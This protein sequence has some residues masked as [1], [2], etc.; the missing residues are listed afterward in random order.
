MS[1]CF[2]RVNSTFSEVSDVI[3]SQIKKDVQRSG[4]CCS[5]DTGSV[6]VSEEEAPPHVQADIEIL[7]KAKMRAL[8]GLLQSHTGWCWLG[9]VRFTNK[10]KK[11][12]QIYST[13]ICS[14]I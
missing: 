8:N 11:N 4:P 2:Y 12:P 14:R 13:K 5:A 6:S 9:L 3:V 7:R 10:K 1:K